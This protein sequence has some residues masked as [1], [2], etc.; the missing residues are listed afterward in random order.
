MA[1]LATTRAA[2]GTLI[3]LSLAACGSGTGGS[4]GAAS[5]AAAAHWRAGLRHWGAAMN[6]AVTGINIAFSRPA[7]ARAIQ[8]GAKAIMVRMATYE[9]TLSGCKA[10]LASL[11]PAPPVLELPRREA[12]HACVNL[13]RAATLVRLG[14]SAI[15]RG[16]GPELL[17]ETSDPLSNGQGGI[18]RALLDAVP[19]SP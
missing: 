19:G 9:H 14:I 5:D 15:Q 3:V 8:A 16:M 6:G 13:Q 7:D 1:P 18:R 2:A 11:G 17:N 12:L 10:R 4:S